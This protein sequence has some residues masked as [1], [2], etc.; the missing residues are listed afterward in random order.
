[1]KEL[2]SKVPEELLS[3][4]SEVC[5]A[6]VEKLVDLS[7][8]VRSTLIDLVSLML[9]SLTQE[10]LRS[11]VAQFVVFIGSALTHSLVAVRMDSLR[12]VKLWLSHYPQLLILHY[13]QLLPQIALILKTHSQLSLNANVMSSS[14]VS[15]KLTTSTISKNT[16]LLVDTL[17]LYLSHILDSTDQTTVSLNNAPAALAMDWTDTIDDALVVP[18]SSPYLFSSLTSSSSSSSASV[19]H[20]GSYDSKMIFG[21]S[22]D[23]TL[24]SSVSVLARSDL[25]KEE[26]VSRYCQYIIPLLMEARVSLPSPP[27]SVLTCEVWMEY[28]PL[29]LEEARH[30]DSPAANAGLLL[31]IVRILRH[32]LVRLQTLSPS[33]LPGFSPMLQKYIFLRFPYTWNSSSRLQEER[34][35]EYVVSIDVS[36]S[37]QDVW[38]DGAE[39]EHCRHHEPVCH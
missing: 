24:A 31:F 39:Y 34:Q 5:S 25:S 3:H 28:A 36:F 12:M 8:A 38:L 6:I 35:S 19:P 13:Q 15:S 27:F 11:Y 2:F 7:A 4:L 32:L 18:L 1:M 10:Q 26:G 16:K 9:S 14:S 37:R 30:R 29:P 33:S 21:G 17:Y 22:S 20:S 23:P